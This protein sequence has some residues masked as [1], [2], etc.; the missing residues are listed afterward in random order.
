MPETNIAA[1][2]PPPRLPRGGRRLGAGRPPSY[3][4][5]LLRKT[6]KLPVS[7]VQQ[8]EVLGGGN[9]SE[10]IRL[11]VETAYTFQGQ[12]WYHLPERLAGP[13]TR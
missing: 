2:S 13:A 12:L 10:G 1:A 3:R 8:L 11:L 5:P 9:L 7:Y 6:V 4:E